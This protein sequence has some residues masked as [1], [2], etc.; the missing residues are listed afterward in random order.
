MASFEI[1][2]TDIEIYDNLEDWRVK[3]LEEFLNEYLKKQAQE[4]FSNYDIS[5]KEKELYLLKGTRGALE[6]FPY[7]Y[8]TTIIF[9]RF[10]SEIENYNEQK[11][12]NNLKEC[13]QYEKLSY[14]PSCIEDNKRILTSNYINDYL[15][16]KEKTLEKEIEKR[17]QK[18]SEKNNFK[19]KL[20][21]KLE[22]KIQN[23]TQEKE[24]EKGMEK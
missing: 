3:N 1:Y 17:K 24:Q 21:N 19:E 14:L 16:K 9:D 5:Q 7:T 6:V 18:K 23:K 15:N 22:E 13:P 12:G 4:K 8:Q 10:K 11:Y 2:D 20:N